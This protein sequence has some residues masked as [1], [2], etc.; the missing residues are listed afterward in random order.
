MIELIEE[1]VG[2]TVRYGIREDGVC[3]AM[4]GDKTMVQRMFDKQ[5]KELEMK[6]KVEIKVLDS[7]TNYFQ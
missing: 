7:F 6:P 2:A 4:Y 1:T 5:K 3:G